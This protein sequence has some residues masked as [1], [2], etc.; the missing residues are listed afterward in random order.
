[1]RWS[2]RNSAHFSTLEE[3]E[4]FLADT[5]I[6]LVPSQPAPWL[7]LGEPGLHT[8]ASAAQGSSALCVVGCSSS[9]VNSVGLHSV[10][11]SNW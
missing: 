5:D 6:R 7:G 2:L 8:P 9:P 10:A 4:R 11:G 1:M 3:L